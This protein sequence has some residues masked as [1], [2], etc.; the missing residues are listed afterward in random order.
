MEELHRIWGKNIE[1]QRLALKLSQ[2][3]LA[4]LVGVRQQT[5]S[6]WEAG[7]NAP[8]DLH[9]IKL[10]EV[11]HRDVSEIFPIMRVSTKASA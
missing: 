11:L 1:R 9:K 8:R 10:A 3:Q 6:S 2:T 4:E 7:E 5:V